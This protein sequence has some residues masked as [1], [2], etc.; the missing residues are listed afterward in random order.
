ME[1]LILN[2]K[3]SND[4]YHKEDYIVSK[5]NK[6]AYEHIKDSDILWGV[7]PYERFLLILGPKFSGKTYLAKIWAEKNS[8]IILDNKSINST[9]YR[10]LNLPL[11]L[12]DIDEIQNEEEF[13]HLFNH[14]I[15]SNY[16]TLFTASF[17]K[18]FN[19]KDLNSRIRSI[20]KVS[21]EEPDEN[22]VKIIIKKLF[23]DRSIKITNE[24]LNYL[25]YR[26]PRNYASINLFVSKTDQ[27]SLTQKREITIPL[28]S[29]I[30][31]SM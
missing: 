3:T 20:N 16:Q 7:M 2:V 10:R 27:E 29:S 14:R 15:D 19:L 24:V 13:F 22:L 30:L 18:N 21:I 26:L 5:C 31:Q 11:I 6:L 23:S 9:E 17:L 12:E 4:S 8:A 25:L 1:Q 28:I